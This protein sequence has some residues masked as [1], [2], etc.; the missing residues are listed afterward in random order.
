MTETLEFYAISIL[1][2]AALEA[3]G[4]LPCRERPLRSADE[5]EEILRLHLL[6]ISAALAGWLRAYQLPALR[7][8]VRRLR[9]EPRS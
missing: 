1:H 8:L 3:S 7:D 6:D 5:A 9:W 4:R 2:S